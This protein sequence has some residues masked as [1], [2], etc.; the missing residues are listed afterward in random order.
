MTV[1][2]QRAFSLTEILV[3]LLIAAMLG[4]ISVP[5]VKNLVQANRSQNIQESLKS[6]LHL[7][8]THSVTHRMKVEVCGSSDGLTCDN[9]WHAGWLIREH[10]S[11]NVIR[12]EQHKATENLIWRGFSKTVRFIPSGHSN[13]SNGTFTYCDEQSNASW[14]IVLNRQGRTRSVNTPNPTSISCDS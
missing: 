1:I 8:R 7:A 9:A 11:R 13:F 3:C 4:S 12:S 2:N 6:A 5:L 14:Q 10:G